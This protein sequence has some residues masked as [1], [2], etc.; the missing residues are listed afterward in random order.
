MRVTTIGPYPLGYSCRI[1]ARLGN[2]IGHRWPVL[3]PI[4]LPLGHLG[5]C[6]WAI[7]IMKRLN[8]GQSISNMFDYMMATERS[9][10]PQQRD[11]VGM[12][13]KEKRQN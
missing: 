9:V 7:M 11:P 13:L 12:A 10:A 8:Y 5:D 4:I 2:R 3:S 1:S 6:D